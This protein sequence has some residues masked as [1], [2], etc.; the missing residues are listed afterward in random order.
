MRR[1][2]DAA[3]LPDDLVHAFRRDGVVV[4]RDLLTP[5]E[6]ATLAAGVERNLA[7][8]SELGMNATGPDRPG[9]FVEDFRNWTRIPEYE[10]V[11]RGSAL[12]RAGAQLMGSRTARIFHDH[13][14][15][16]EPG[17]LDPSPWHQDQP[18]YCIDGTQ[19]V[20]FWIPLD[21][22]TR[23]NTLEFVAGSHADGRW[24]MP[25]SFVRKTPMVFEEGALDEVP[26]VEADRD[27]HP[28]VGWAMEP[29]DAVAFNMLTLHAAGGSPTRRR[30]FSLR[31]TG[32][33][34]TYAPRPHRTSPPFPELAATDGSGLAAGA[35]LAHP[36]FPVLWPT[37][38]VDA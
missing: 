3:P 17:T 16:K 27:A 26:D 28:I 23:E 2:T 14:L 18:Y 34:V 15:V 11:V 6:V 22:V 35:P 37:G 10:R 36:L 33:D 20:S 25:R 4:L 29:G 1:V 38:H 8:L 12:A 32:D 5:E 21:P 9:A 24:F 31:L 7:S 30:A 13:L 19:T